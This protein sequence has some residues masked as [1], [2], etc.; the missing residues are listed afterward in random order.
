MVRVHEKLPIIEIDVLQP[1]WSI[2]GFK[3]S[4]KENGL[5]AYAYLMPLQD[6]P[7]RGY[8]LEYSYDSEK[9][10]GRN[11]TDRQHDQGK[12]LVSHVRA[13]MLDAIRLAGWQ[14]VGKQETGRDI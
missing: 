9:Q 11:L 12:I 13:G 6:Q 7:T 8:V 5:V 10:P 14:V 3:A 4:W 2:K 1:D